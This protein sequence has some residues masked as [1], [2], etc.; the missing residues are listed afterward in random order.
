MPQS[1][2]H[3]MLLGKSYFFRQHSPVAHKSWIQVTI[4]P[5]GP[6]LLVTGC[7][8]LDV[9]LLLSEKGENEQ[10]SLELVVAPSD[11]AFVCHFWGTMGAFS[12]DF[13]TATR[14]PSL[15]PTWRP[16]SITT[17]PP[18]NWNPRPSHSQKT[19]PTLISAKIP[20]NGTRRPPEF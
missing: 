17:Q 18:N 5:D 4:N 10:E 11:S 16:S 6:P 20:W 13:R 14:L 19:P 7:Q 3:T 15:P 12:Q 9:L 8:L 1:S 2:R